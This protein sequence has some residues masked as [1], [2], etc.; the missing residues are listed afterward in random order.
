MI[1]MS[2]KSSMEFSLWSTVLATRIS[3][4]VVLAFL[5][6]TSNAHQSSG[7]QLLKQWNVADLAELMQHKELLNHPGFPED[8]TGHTYSYTAMPIPQNFYAPRRAMRRS[9]LSPMEPVAPRRFVNYGGL[10]PYRRSLEDRSWILAN[11]TNNNDDVETEM[12]GDD[13][14]ELRP[15]FPE[16]GNMTD[17][18][19]STTEQPGGEGFI[20]TELPVVTSSPVTEESSPSERVSTAPV[21]EPAETPED[22]ITPELPYK[23]FNEIPSDTTSSDNVIYQPIRLHFDISELMSWTSSNATNKVRVDYLVHK[24][25]P[26]MAQLWSS[27]LTVVPVQGSLQIDHVWCPFGKDDNV[28]F[29]SGVPD[30]DMIVFVTANSEACRNRDVLASAFSCY[31]DQYQRPTAGT[32]DFCFDTIESE[33]LTSL[34][35]SGAALKGTESQFGVPVTSNPKYDRMLNMAIGTAV[36]EFAHILGVTSRDMPFFYDWT[37][38][39]PRTSSPKE[40]IVECVTG[41]REPVWLPDETTLRQVKTA[42]GVN[43]FEVTLPSVRQV[44]RNQFDCQRMEG[45]R[46]ENQPTDGDCFGAHF[47][48]RLFFPEAM[49]SVLGGVPEILSSLALALLHDSGWYSPVYEVAKVTPWG[50]GAGCDFVEKDCIVDG[51]I[52]DYG[53]GY[54]CNTEFKKYDN[55]SIAIVGFGCDPT[56]THIGTCDLVDYGPL[57]KYYD[58]P[59]KKYQYFPERPLLGSIMSTADY[60]P[61]FTLQTYSCREILDLPKG[62]IPVLSREAEAL[63]STSHNAKCIPT[64]NGKRPVC[65]E[66]ACDKANHVVKLKAG[67]HIISCS[68]DFEE[69]FLPGTDITLSCPTFFFVVPGDCLSSKL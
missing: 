58:P 54:F 59:D 60:C 22:E 7:I 21:T 51:E 26:G 29:S 35:D 5:S 19:E 52:P 49:S 9:D 61:T 28:A 64:V 44:A 36:H 8:W 25:L 38:G 57:A 23:V 37:T 43:Y 11:L 18:I 45:A 20:P 10:H 15:V 39:L 47:D 13:D 42:D 66:A 31:W 62:Y 53:E 41:N 40:E 67:E 12:Q 68:Y 50:H 32:I 56:H 65:L 14:N 16:L 34:G 27:A 55:G 30:T 6:S 4:L 17:T 63:E 3:H 24:V 2:Q 33:H 46:L 48:E 1:L 69:H